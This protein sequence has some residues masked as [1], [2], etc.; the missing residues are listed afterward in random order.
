MAQ[1]PSEVTRVVGAPDDATTTRPAASLTTAQIRSQ[2]EETRAE[3]S[4]TINAIQER[5]SPSRIITD[6]KETVKEA[7]VGGV[8]SLTE[9]VSG[10]LSRLSAESSLGA[11][12]VLQRVRNH[13][14]PVALIGLAATGIL[15]RAVR[16]SQT[17]SS[18]E[19]WT[20][21]EPYVSQEKENTTRIVRTSA[22]LLAGAGAGVACW[23]LWTAQSAK[24]GFQAPEHNDRTLAEGTRRVG[25]LSSEA[26][27]RTR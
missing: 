12:S 20:R 23:T 25:A 22:K 3:M 18:A 1:D 19:A 26:F 15:L 24:A 14:V 6:A 8:K 2:I 5:L 7:T 13:P 4:E 27:A 21:A 16:R 11:Q 17:R 9:Q 10:Q